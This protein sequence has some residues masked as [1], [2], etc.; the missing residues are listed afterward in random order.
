MMLTVEEYMF[1]RAQMDGAKSA[2]IETE[3][4][5]HVKAPRKRRKSSY[6]KAMSKELK[7]LN[8]RFRTK[9]GE[10]RKGYNAARIMKIAHKNVRRARK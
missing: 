7:A 5:A 4:R 2:V 1:L 10:Y 8:T 6:S 9:K 3:D